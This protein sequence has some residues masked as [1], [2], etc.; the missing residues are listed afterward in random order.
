MLF[1]DVIRTKRDG[2]ELSDEQIQFLVDG[3][4]D[5][6][7]P[8]EQVSALAM[9]VVFNSMSFDETANLTLAMASSGTVLD[10]S[11]E[12]LDGPVVDKHSTGGVGDKV[13]FM[14]APIAAACGCH[15]PM[16]SGRGLGH[17]GGTTDKAEA[18]PGYNTAPDFATFKKVVRDTGCAIIGQTSDLAPADRRLYAIRDVTATVESVPLITASILS[19]KIAAGLNALVMDVKV[20]SG[21]FMKSPERANK[22]AQSIIATAAKANLRTHALITDMNQVLGLTVGNALE[23]QE[24]V[25]YLRNERREARL[26]DVTLGLCVEM[27]VVT[28]LET[29]RDAARQRCDDAVT[30]GRAAEIFSAMVAALGGP[31]DFLENS[32]AYLAK[33]PVVRP[34][35]ANG[36]LTTVNTRGVGNAIIELGGGRHR[37]GEVLDLSVGFSDMAPIG[38]LLDAETPL[39]VVHAASE[40]A[41]AQAEINLLAACAT[42]SAAPAESP[43][44]Y[45]IHSGE[46]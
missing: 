35:H 25:A 19:K 16:I 17:T 46:D 20:G 15:V 42:G 38:T 9:A 4:A 11:Q 40:D 6:S 8:A 41:A 5:E 2:G 43:V 34:I 39:A 14:L 33:A 21:A 31:A 44:I 27:L 36:Y 26:D 22:L 12:E 29:D 45:E 7:I 13:S 24:V 23:I 3:L 28:G 30:S 1:T 18:I 32:E 10:W 37:V